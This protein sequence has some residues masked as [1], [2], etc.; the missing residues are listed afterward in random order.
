MPLL[1]GFVM[2]YL[3]P[4]SVLVHPEQRA[5]FAIFIGVALSISA[6]PVI[7][8]TLL[9]LGL[10]KTD[11]GLLVMTAAMI[12]DLVGWVAFSILLG[13]MRGGAVDLGKLATTIGVALLFGAACL[14]LGT[15]RGRRRPRSH[16][17][18]GRSRA[19]SHPLAAHRG[20]DP[21]RERDAGD[22]HP[23]RARRLHRRRHGRRLAAPARAHAPDHPAV[24]HQRVRAGVLRGRRAARR[25][26]REL[27]RRALPRRVRRR[28]GGE[29][30][31]VQRAARASRGCRGANR[32]WWASG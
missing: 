28:V 31:R 29:G 7:A 25:L 11:I 13:P 9:D 5:L 26:L 32:W 8:K 23:R 10:F 30:R 24:R 16:R 15:A 6:L 4:D 12:N 3:V 21:R 2:G 14:V 27:R 1:G 22:R 17:E 19:G 18:A 20:R